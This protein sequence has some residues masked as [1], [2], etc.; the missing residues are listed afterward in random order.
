MTRRSR[1]YRRPLT[2]VVLGLTMSLPLLGPPLSVSAA[3]TTWTQQSPA[4]S[5]PAR[6]SASMAYDSASSSVVLFG[7]FNTVN[8]LAD[9]WTWDGTT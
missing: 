3:G 1:G 9:T 6:Y 8:R 4:T 2:T 5:P 7:G